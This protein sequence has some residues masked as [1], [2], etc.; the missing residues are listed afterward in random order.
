MITA[1]IKVVKSNKDV[2]KKSNSNY[3]RKII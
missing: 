1:P 3:R 2:I